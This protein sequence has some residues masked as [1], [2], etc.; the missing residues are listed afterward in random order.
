MAAIERPVF[1]SL[2]SIIFPRGRL[3]SLHDVSLLLLLPH[4]HPILLLLLLLLLLFLLLLLLLLSFS[5]TTTKMRFRDWHRRLRPS[6]K[7][8]KQI[9]ILLYVI[10][11]QLSF[12]G[13][14]L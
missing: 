7:T 13:N 8:L 9:S 10:K 1:F 3:L 14:G 11:F 12:Y 5:F 6:N 2:T 4:I